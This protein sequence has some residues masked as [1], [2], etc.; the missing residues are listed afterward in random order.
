[1]SSN[2]SRLTARVQVVQEH[3]RLESLHD[4]DGL[5]QLFSPSALHHDA[6]AGEQR[7]EPGAIR[8]YHEELFRG[9]PDFRLDLTQTYATEEVVVLESSVS[10]THQ[11]EFKGVPATGKRFEIPVCGI[12]TFD[13]ND[14]I[15]GEKIYY[16]RMTLLTQLGV[17]PG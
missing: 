4:L 13:E 8:A 1:M 3:L 9:F 5:M 11:G 14:R 17:L 10:G 6:A 16:D 7:T 15:A 2:N 12:Y